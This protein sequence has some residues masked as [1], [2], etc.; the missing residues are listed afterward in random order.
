MA[1]NYNVRT[2]TC[3][4]SLENCK[5]CDKLPKTEVKRRFSATLC[6]LCSYSIILIPGYDV[7]YN[8]LNSALICYGIF[9]VR[10]FVIIMKTN[11]FITKKYGKYENKITYVPGNI[12]RP[13]R[14]FSRSSYWIK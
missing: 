3:Q 14:S 10:R 13:V 8:S 1:F 6:H 12:W 9:K 5:I 2:P 7:G 4:M 11:S